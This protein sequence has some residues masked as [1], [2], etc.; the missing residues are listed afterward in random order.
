[1]RVFKAA[2]VICPKKKTQVSF[3]LNFIKA[4]DYLFIKL[5]ARF[6]VLWL[7]AGNRSSACPHHLFIVCG[8]VS[9]KKYGSELP[10]IY[11]CH[12]LIRTEKSCPLHYQFQII[13]AAKMWD[14]LSNHSLAADLVQIAVIHFCTRKKKT[15]SKN[16]YICCVNNLSDVSWDKNRWKTSW[17]FILSC[18]CSSRITL[19][20]FG[21]SLLLQVSQ[22][23]VASS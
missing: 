21:L 11:P 6:E 5:L 8:T 13:L 7:C 4:C 20:G 18:L 10:K 14:N 17:S 15:K 2:R 12:Y 23:E 1:M 19:Y 9:I 16:P 22:L 3:I